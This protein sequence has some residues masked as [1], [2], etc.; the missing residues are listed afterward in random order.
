MN[1]TASLL[2]LA[3]KVSFNNWLLAKGWVVTRVDLIAT[4]A[5]VGCADQMA[6]KA[7]VNP[8]NQIAASWPGG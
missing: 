6:T 7:A 3:E 4:L 1:C 2:S 5:A 8:G